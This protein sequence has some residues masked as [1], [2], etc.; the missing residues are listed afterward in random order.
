MEALSF[1]ERAAFEE[2]S[3]GLSDKEVAT[4]LNKPV[5]TVKTQK[6]S[7]YRKLGISKESELVIYAVCEQL[8]VEFDLKE[9]RKHGLE[10]L[11]S[12]L[13]ILMQVTCH[14]IDLR[15][16]SIRSVTRTT[17]RIGARMSKKGCNDIDLD[18]WKT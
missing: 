1:A 16:T 9:I 4:N 7:I 5:W 15:R 17:A 13:F 11:F 12:V 10:I 8:K 2:Y 18:V 6:K 3:K 14:S